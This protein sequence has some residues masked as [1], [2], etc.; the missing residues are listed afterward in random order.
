MLV[1]QYELFKIDYVEFITSMYIRFT[2]I[3]NG[4]KSLGK[5]YTNSEL[6]RKSIGLCLGHKKPK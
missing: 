2:D 6:V 5:V 3:I 1:H 4:L